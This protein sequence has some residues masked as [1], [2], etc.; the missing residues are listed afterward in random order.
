MPSIRGSKDAGRPTVNEKSN[1]QMQPTLPPLPELRPLEPLEPF[2]ELKL[3][4]GTSSNG[5]LLK[6][7]EDDDGSASKS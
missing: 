6:G 7:Q 5:A 3:N 1:G 2:K 4:T